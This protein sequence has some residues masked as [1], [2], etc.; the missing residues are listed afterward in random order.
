MID[1]RTQKSC[2]RYQR[3]LCTTIFCLVASLNLYIFVV[4]GYD[5]SR[6][7]TF[8]ID[9][10]FK[11]CQGRTNRSSIVYEVSYFACGGNDTACIENC[12]LFREFEFIFK[13]ALAP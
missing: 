13:K 4:V 8:L 10:P 9:T 2:M 7:Y 1:F 12:E 11:G 5:N 6:T 3:H